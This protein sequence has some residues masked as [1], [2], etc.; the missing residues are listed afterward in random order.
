MEMIILFFET[1]VN[2]NCFQ[3]VKADGSFQI[4]RAFRE[5]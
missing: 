3:E 4:E 5:E 2:Y 1:S